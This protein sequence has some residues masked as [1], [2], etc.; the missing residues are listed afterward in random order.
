MW[1]GKS[2]HSR[3]WRTCLPAASNFVPL[4]AWC[5]G[6]SKKNKR[7]II[8]FLFPLWSVKQSIFVSPYCIPYTSRQTFQLLKLLQIT[9]SIFTQ[10]IFENERKSCLLGHYTTVH[11][12]PRVDTVWDTSLGIFFSKILPKAK[13]FQ[14]LS[15]LPN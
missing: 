11:F 8:E 15:I 5:V 2:F 3:P 1:E 13:W 4:V 14:I 9:H 12:V 10:W 7:K 6:K